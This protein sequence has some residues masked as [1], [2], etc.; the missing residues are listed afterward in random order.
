MTIVV[1]SDDRYAI[2]LAVTLYST[3]VHLADG[4]TL[5]IIVVDGGMS[6]DSRRRLERVVKRANSKASL[7][8]HNADTAIF[9]GLKTS[10]W[11]STAN[12]LRLLI[13]DIVSETVELAVYLDSDLMV[14]SD[15]SDLWSPDSSHGGRAIEAVGDFHHRKI[16]T[17]FGEQACRQLGI[18]P[19]TPYFNSGVLVIDVGLWRTEEIPAKAI[20]FVRKHGDVMRHS[21]Q[22]A[23]N[24]VLLGRWHALDDRWNVMLASLERF[25]SMTAVDSKERDTKRFELLEGGRIYH[26]TGPKKPWKPGYWG[27]GGHE[28]RQLL[29]SSGWF[30]GRSEAIKWALGYWTRSPYTWLRLGYR[31]IRKKAAIRYHSIRNK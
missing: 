14:R 8:W 21:D 20:E 12:Y 17:V 1:G 13:P 10:K 7:E 6:T 16:R 31:R 26:F 25:L 23:L 27:P 11:G 5:T 4:L 18:D 19:D 22:D 29:R 2:G 30:E 28:Y 3:L 24:A 9:D 15:I